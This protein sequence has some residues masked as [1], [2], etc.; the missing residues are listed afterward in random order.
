MTLTEF[1]SQLDTLYKSRNTKAESSLLFPFTCPITQKTFKTG[2]STSG[3]LSYYT[4]MTSDIRKYQA[5]NYKT[6]T[7]EEVFEKFKTAIETKQKLEQINQ[8][9]SKISSLHEMQE[10][11]NDFIKVQKPKITDAELPVVSVEKIKIH[12]NSKRDL[13]YFVFFK[14]D[15]VQKDAARIFKG[16]LVTH[17]SANNPQDIYF[18]SYIHLNP[19]N[20]M[21]ND[22][23]KHANTLQK[24]DMVAKQDLLKNKEYVTLT[25]RIK[26]LNAQI[27]NLREQHHEVETK[28]A[29]I[30]E[31][32]LDS[33][34]FESY[35][36]HKTKAKTKIKP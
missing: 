22:F 8:S 25:A 3:F 32:T 18:K 30:R 26:E 5:K 20:Q 16:H 34:T 21:V 29:A 31:Q 35:F 36:Q 9:F 11:I 4:K 10:F 6:L 27:H 2:K 15:N 13:N 33:L 14:M 23:Q 12:R 19:L 24:V 17:V 7:D 1:Q 28:M